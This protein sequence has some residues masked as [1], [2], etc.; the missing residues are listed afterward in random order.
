MSQETRPYTLYAKESVQMDM[1]ITTTLGEIFEL[2]YPCW[3]YYVKFTEEMTC[4]YL[5]VKRSFGNLLEINVNNDEGA[6]DLL[7]WRVILTYPLEIPFTEYS[8]AGSSCQWKNYQGHYDGN[9][10]VM[11]NSDEELKNYIQCTGESDYFE[12]DFSK[13]TLLLAHGIERYVVH[14]DYTSLQQLS[15]LNYVMKINFITTGFAMIT[16]WQVPIMVSKIADSIDIK[17]IVMIS[18]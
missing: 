8:L 17:L 4:K 12:V 1:T 5:I 9:V 6:E 10:V 2:D 16:D 18:P 13:Y 11:I 3:V 7:T 15:E 14:F